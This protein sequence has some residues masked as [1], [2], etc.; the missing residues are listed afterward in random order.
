MQLFTLSFLMIFTKYVKP[1]L[2]LSSAYAH[3]SKFVFYPM[4]NDISDRRVAGMGFQMQQQIAAIETSRS[5][6]EPPKRTVIF[7]IWLLIVFS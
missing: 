6:L 2:T 7:K 3:C 5:S 1:C 4:P